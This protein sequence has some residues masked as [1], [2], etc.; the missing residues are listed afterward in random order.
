M[1]VTRGLG[2]QTIVTDG[3]GDWPDYGPLVLYAVYH[4]L[5]Q[6]RRVHFEVRG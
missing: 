5:I 2:G 3:L 1:I 4:F 6:R